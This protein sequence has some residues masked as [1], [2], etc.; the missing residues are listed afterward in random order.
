MT[1]KRQRQILVVG[2]GKDHCPEIAYQAAYQVGLEVAKHHGILISGG[3]GGVMEAASRG[4]KDGDGFVIGIIPQD[5]KGAANESCD[6]VIATG[7]GF[8][9]DFLTAYS[10]DAIIV[11]GGGAGTMI[12]IAAAYQ[13]Q[14]PIIALKGTGGMADRLVDTYIDDRRIERILGET[15][16]QKAVETAFALIESND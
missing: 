9:R 16:P 14:I 11:V 4:A 6:A 7:M 12:E 13:K 10:A 2:F 3:L 1:M 15:T 5:D 8:A